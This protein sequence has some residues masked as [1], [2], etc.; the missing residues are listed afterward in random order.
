[1]ERLDLFSH[2]EGSVHVFCQKALIEIKYNWLK[3]HTSKDFLYCEGKVR[4]NHFCKE[5][6]VEIF[7]RSNIPPKIYIKNPFIKYNDEIHMYSD[8]SLCLYYPPDMPWRKHIM[9]SDTIV[10]WISE[11]IIL[12]EL[13]KISGKW[14][15]A[16]VRH[17]STK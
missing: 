9:L 14:E 2:I 5:Y 15:G 3:C 12:Y 4:P 13:W 16:E 11:W 17:S 8:N 1:M 7:Y 10:P 6:E